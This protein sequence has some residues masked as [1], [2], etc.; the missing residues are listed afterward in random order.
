M[1]AEAVKPKES[2]PLIIEEEAGVIQ[3][4]I[5]QVSPAQPEKRKRDDETP[6]ES[7]T[8]YRQGSDGHRVSTSRT[9]HDQRERSL[10][11]PFWKQLNRRQPSNEFRARSIGSF[12]ILRRENGK[13]C[14]ED[15]RYM[16]SNVTS[17]SHF[18]TFEEFFQFSNIPG[19]Q[20]K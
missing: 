5:Q 9:T 10:Q 12:S 2:E 1:S 16:R 17:Q 11:V 19:K 7:P 6:N 18:D 8:K 3:R 15:Q 13:D 14:F 4:S 20:R